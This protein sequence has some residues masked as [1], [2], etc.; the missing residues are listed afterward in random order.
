MT[1]DQVIV[2]N[3]KVVEIKKTIK[4]GGG[5]TLGFPLSKAMKRGKAAE[6]PAP[7]LPRPRFKTVRP[8]DLIKQMSKAAYA[9]FRHGRIAQRAAGIFKV[10][11]R[12]V[13][14]RT[15][16]ENNLSVAAH[17][18]GHAVA[19]LLYPE[20]KT[21]A[22]DY[23]GP[24]SGK[25]RGELVRLGKDLY[26][27]IVPT[28]GYKSE[29]FAEF[30]R[31]WME[32]RPQAKKKAPTF[33][34]D[35]VKRL[36]RDDDTVRAARIMDQIATDWQIYNK[37]PASGKILA[38][39]Q[40]HPSQRT[41]IT[42][43]RLY[44]RL[45]DRHWFYD[46]A[47]KAMAGGDF[48]HGV[49]IPSTE[50]WTM[51]GWGNMPRLWLHEGQVDVQ[52]NRLLAFLRRN[53][54]DDDAIR[55]GKKPMMSAPNIKMDVEQKT[56]AK[57][58]L[59]HHQPKGHVE[60]RRDGNIYI[61]KEG[62]KQLEKHNFDAIGPSLGKIL[63]P[64]RDQEPLAVEEWQADTKLGKLLTKKFGAKFMDVDGHRG[65]QRFSVYA[66]ARRAQYLYKK[67][68]IQSGIEDFADA[69]IKELE[70]PA[71][72]KAFDELQ[73]YQRNLLTMMM[74]E[75]ILS[76][77][78]LKKILRLNEVYI[79]LRRAVQG[80]ETSGIGSRVGG[81]SKV[82]KRIKG[83]DLDILNP[84]E[85]IV[86]NT[87]LVMAEIKRNRVKRVL[88]EY[89]QDNPGSGWVVEEIPKKQRA[90]NVNLLEAKGEI[91]RILEDAGVD[92]K[93]IDD[94]ML[95]V[96]VR[97]WRPEA[98][99]PK[100]AVGYW[101]DGG[102]TF[103][104][105]DED[106]YRSMIGM[107]EGQ[108]NMFI[109]LVG[110]PARTLRAGA[111]LNP[112]FL[113]KNA[114]R[115][116][117]QAA[118]F[119]EQTFVPVVDTIKG[120]KSRILRDDYYFKYQA[121]GAGHATLISMDRNYF[122]HD[123]RELMTSPA[124]LKQVVGH[125]AHPI[126]VMRTLSEIAEEATRVQIFKN[127]L[128]AGG[129]M[130]QDALMRAAVQARDTTLDFSRMGEWMKKTG[131]NQMV[132]F[133]NAQV[134]GVDKFGRVLVK[135]FKKP[136][137]AKKFMT[138]MAV[139]VAAPAVFTFL[140][141]KDDEKYHGLPDYIK[142]MTHVIPTGRDD[143]PFFFLPKP[144]EVG[145]MYGSL[146]ERA[147]HAMYGENPEAFE[148]YDQSLRDALIPT[149]IPT[150]LAASWENWANESFFTGR[151]IEPRSETKLD[152]EMRFGPW[153]SETAKV[154]S[155]AI[156]KTPGVGPLVGWAMGARRGDVS[157]RQVDNIIRGWTAGLG[158]RY[159][160]PAIDSILS[161][162][163]KWIAPETSK[164]LG[165]GVK[166]AMDR[167]WTQEWFRSF[168]VRD[169]QVG[170]GTVDKFYKR[171]ETSQQARESFL[172]KTGDV[173]DRYIKR[174]GKAAL[175]S[176]YLPLA[177]AAANMSALHRKMREIYAED[178]PDRKELLAT[179]R[180]IVKLAKDGM[181]QAKVL[182]AH[183]EAL[184][185]MYV[186][187]LEREARGVEAPR[188]EGL[189]P[190]IEDFVINQEWDAYNEWFNE[191][192]GEDQAWAKRVF[193]NYR[194]KMALPLPEQRLKN[195]P[196]KRREKIRLGAKEKVAQ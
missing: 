36:A 137:Q 25:I 22:F 26:G 44:S 172:A 73:T 140:L 101:R 109:R 87:Y 100:G 29:G 121:S 168:V 195:V 7:K 120:A 125:A 31:L 144:F 184:E 20:I 15:G 6:P 86:A 124:F 112:P 185:A 136:K 119:A 158:T 178:K 16:Y 174:E 130:D 74:H 17:E 102:M 139:Y 103:L 18:M 81:T 34:A 89:A 93:D 150:F 152:A 12:V 170:R 142:D 39:L 111:T 182:E 14:L 163:I 21:L 92:P 96:W 59:H 117:I 108:A 194:N 72:K 50:V 83:S 52:E 127:D 113:I 104:K 28:G 67:R 79:P 8:S 54:I 175:V 75:G 177:K 122:Q 132:A 82:V 84:I 3:P 45:I 131:A 65:M 159:V 187:A 11:E 46:V 48:I 171:L 167:P 133:L 56:I 63:A 188:R 30:I 135:S 145:V 176:Q 95:D 160:V 141:N 19:R 9:P 149:V 76:K 51:R 60:V 181:S 190:I 13:R 196:K 49:G 90:T 116:A 162:T 147:L 91:K 143:V 55:A 191:L 153:T 179:W 37:L 110:A 71:F 99:V 155:A 33:Y 165:I 2:L 173:R 27:K 146:M 41:P 148:G 154:T 151:P 115:D 24:G 32:D 10:Q 166:D 161:P 164:D 157:P 180:R 129:K 128:N 94:S 193:Q 42:L 64:V 40:K 98:V 78:E 114:T 68:G 4:P 118:L 156:R 38:R 186:D 126:D 183:P 62:A 43:N 53:N 85:T 169:D 80:P 61:T 134:Q 105:L 66:V 1:A 138:N 106:L 5:V 69:A 58:L 57:R 23:K 77:A 123:L 88:H 97:I 35:F 70:T 107:D 47:T 189:R 192:P